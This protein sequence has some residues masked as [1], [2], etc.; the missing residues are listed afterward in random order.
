M[1]S[2]PPKL[3]YDLERDLRVLVAMAASLTPY[4]YESEMYGYLGGDLP[5]LTLGGL[6]LRLYR[7][8]RVSDIL[9]ADQ[10]KMVQEAQANFDTQT[11]QWAVHYEDKLWREL[12][13]RID[14]FNHYLN[15]CFEDSQS[16]TAN[17]PSQAEKRTMI[18]HL[19]TEM[20]NRNA[21]TNDL[22]ERLAGIDRKL[23]QQLQESEFIFDE[24]LSS[25][26]PREQFWWFYGYIAE[27]FC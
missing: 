11:S 4:L 7:L 5:K 9:T 2:H 22:Q 13:S 27:S 19:K 8:S 1:S 16:C 20:E 3:S 17:Y 25:V 21:L 6:L 18:E 14:A 23:R 24:R 12:R 15:E 10:R 26:Y